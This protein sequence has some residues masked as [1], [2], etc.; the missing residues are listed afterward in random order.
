MNR[1][2]ELLPPPHFLRVN[3]SCIVRKS[4]IKY[5]HDMHIELNLPRSNRIPIGPTYWEN[6]KKYIVD[7]F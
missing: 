7:L 6:M 5:I 1:I 4:A 2:E 3:R